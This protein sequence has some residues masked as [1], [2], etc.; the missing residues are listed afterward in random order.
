M[1]SHNANRYRPPLFLVITDD[2][3]NDVALLVGAFDILEGRGAVT[4]I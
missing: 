2:D 1:P 4:G 3:D